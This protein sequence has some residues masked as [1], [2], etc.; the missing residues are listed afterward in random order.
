MDR[1]EQGLPGRED[2]P[3]HRRR[4]HL[5]MTHVS[6]TPAPIPPAERSLRIAVRDRTSSLRS[7]GWVALTLALAC[8]ALAWAQPAPAAAKSFVVKCAS[9]HVA[10]DDPIVLPGQPGAAHR[11]EFFG[12]RGVTAGSTAPQ[13]HRAR[14]SCRLRAD[15]AAYWAPTLEVD[16]RLVRGSLAAY[17]SRAGK[18]RGA[19]PPAG[20]KLLAGDPHATQPQ[21][22]LVTS[23][24]CVGARGAPRRAKQVPVCTRGERLGAWI[25]FP[26]CWDG[27]NLDSANHRTH[28]AAA[29]KGRCPRTHPVELMQLSMLVS[30]PTRPAR[31]ARI[32]L[33]GGRLAATGMH[34]DFWNTW[35]QPTL[36]QLR[37]DC[38]EVAADCGERSSRRYSSAWPAPEFGAPAAGSGSG[39]TGM[40]M[41]A[42]P[43]PCPVPAAPGSCDCSCCA[44]RASST[45]VA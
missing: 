8:T 42:A 19:A 2:D 45:C 24:T 17:Y 14:T 12:A 5:L 13:L 20:L 35:Q 6:R 3:D 38:I 37:W 44:R 11:H 39:M 26:D 7:N 31:D 41:P 9:T 29:W 32:T 25:V 4:R 15:T 1:L 27:R 30:W 34:A 23:W 43:A 21:S 33:A 18:A 28:V 36:R 40:S 22:L 16:G 10:G